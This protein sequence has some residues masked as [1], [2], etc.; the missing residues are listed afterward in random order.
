M[1]LNKEQIKLNLIQVLNESKIDYKIEELDMQIFDKLIDDLCDL[2]KSAIIKLDENETSVLRMRL[3]IFNNGQI[4]TYKNIEKIIEKT[5]ERIRQILYKSYKIAYSTMVKE[6]IPVSKKER[7]SSFDIYDGIDD[8]Q[9]GELG[10]DTRM[11]NK[12]YKYN[13]YTVS[14]LLGYGTLEFRKMGLRD[15]SLEILYSSIHKKNLK[16]IEELSIDEKRVVVSKSTQEQIDNSSLY[17]IDGLSE[18]FL[19]TR[20]DRKN[21]IIKGLKNNS[22]LNPEIVKRALNIGI[23][24]VKTKVDE[25]DTVAQSEKIMN[26]DISDF[27][28]SN[29]LYNCLCRSNLRTVNDIVKL[30]SYDLDNIRYLGSKSKEELIEMIHNLGL[31]FADEDEIIISNKEDNSIQLDLQIIGLKRK[32]EQLIKR[33]NDLTLKKA[34]L[35]ARSKQ[36]DIEINEVMQQINEMNKG[37]KNGQTR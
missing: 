8:F 5:K 26:V 12:L 33:Y 27:N 4:Q 11:N 19:N 16:L 37:V 24:L 29:R 32:E 18:E 30:N 7:M 22:S 14:D 36:L 23:K 20:I 25:E 10:L 2:S 21:F 6:D 35:E 13:I 31:C 1:E 3:G 9:I 34:K 28:L 15:I 17:W